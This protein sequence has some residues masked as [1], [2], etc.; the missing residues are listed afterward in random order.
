MLCAPEEEGVAAED[1]LLRSQFGMHR[2]DWSDPD[3]TEFHL[4]HGDWLRL[5]R[6][7]RFEVLDL[8]E[9]QP[10]VGAIT[11]YPFVTLEWA[12]R[13]PCEEVWRARLA[14]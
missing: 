9:L 10:S 14:S 5:L 12:R 13:W 6:A 1:R 8:I 4:S 7:N 3:S 11:R 2:F